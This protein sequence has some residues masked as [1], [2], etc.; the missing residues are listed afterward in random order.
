MS[1]RIGAA[2]V[3]AVIFAAVSGP[4]FSQELGSA[5]QGH[6]LAETVCAE[7]HAVEKGALRSRNSHAPTF[8]SI[9]AMPGMTATA[10]RVWLRSAHREMPNLVLKPD[11]VDNVIAYLETLK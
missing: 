3:V 6:M 9:A 1:A 4:S 2:A 11:E 7:C 10:V 8:E 5:R